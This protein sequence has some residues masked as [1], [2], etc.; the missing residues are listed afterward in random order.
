MIIKA[1]R[2][3]AVAVLGLTLGFTVAQ[4]D[5]TIE[6]STSVEGVGAMALGNMTGTSKTVI[7]GDK[8]RTDTDTKMSSKVV[9][10]LARNAA[11]PNAEIILLD[12]DK[13]YHLNINKKEYTETT[14]E[15]VHAQMQK[16]SDQMNS[17]EARQQPSAVDQSKC[18]WLPPKV[19]VNKTGEKAQ[20]AGYDSE[21]VTITASQPCQDKDT[22][23]IC[24][25]ALVLDQWMAPGFAES[26]EVRKFYSSYAT[27]MGMEPSSSE[28]AAQRAKLMFSQYKG[29]WTEVASKM[30]NVK[31]YPVKSSFT[32]AL[33][34]AQCKDSNAQQAQSSQSQSNQSAS[35]QSDG[36]ASG[37][38]GIAGVMAGKLGGLF[39]KNKSD[40]D[41]P[42]AQPAPVVTPVAVPEGDVAL[43][44]VS[45]Q[46]ISVSTNAASADAFMVPAGFKKQE[47]KTQ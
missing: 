25:V 19:S 8:L 7:S 46:L 3:A 6:R 42:A 12:Q 23:S 4:A 2:S 11:G 22:G 33:G 26:T 18:T 17:N 47:L 10:F 38:A 20:F 15:Q 45:S 35:G 30:Q 34:G 28:D 21:R 14:F 16:A 43:M 37:P 13:L 5:V 39:H 36:T 1:M 9:G 44:T 31:G 41:A 40:A 32:L 24:E 27:K 29:I